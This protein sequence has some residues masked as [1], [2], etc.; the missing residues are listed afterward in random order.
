MYNASNPTSRAILA[1]K[2]SY[3]PGQT[4]KPRPD[5]N[6]LRKHIAAVS[7]LSEAKVGCML[8]VVL[9]DT[10][11]LSPSEFLRF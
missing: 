6:V 5:S 1:L 3:T 4:V 2:P 9:R 7:C 11:V 8:N 10:R